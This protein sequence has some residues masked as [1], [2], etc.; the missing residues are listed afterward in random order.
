M[1][2]IYCYPLHRHKGPRFH[3]GGHTGTAFYIKP[4]GTGCSTS[5]RLHEALT[6]RE[7][8]TPLHDAILNSQLQGAHPPAGYH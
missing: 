7:V 8:A 2:H 4:S 6:I 5:G 3:L 1:L